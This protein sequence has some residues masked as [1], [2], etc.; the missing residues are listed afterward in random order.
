MEPEDSDSDFYDEP[1]G[2]TEEA[3]ELLAKK[4]KR[5]LMAKS[6]DKAFNLRK[7]FKKIDIDKI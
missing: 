6:K 3:G 2:Y 1:A 4:F 5:C 7:E